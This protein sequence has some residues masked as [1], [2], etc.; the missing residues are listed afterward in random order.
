MYN[1]CNGLK[2]SQN[3]HPMPKSMEKLSSMK[4]VP[5]A[6]EA[7]DHYSNGLSR[8]Q[9]RTDGW[10]EQRDGNPKEEPKRN[11]RDKKHCT[12]TKSAFGKL[13]NRLGEKTISDLEDVWMDTLKTEKQGRQKWK[14]NF[15]EL[16]HSYTWC[17]LC[18]T[19]LIGEEREKRTEETFETI[20]RMFPN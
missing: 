4:P 17:N 20:M 12:E 18:I 3:H 16:W 19:G 6:K 15:Q 7:G 11:T 8:Q 13:I 2:T 9:A 1:K 5:G 10:C 14:K